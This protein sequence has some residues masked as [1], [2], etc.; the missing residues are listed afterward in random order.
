MKVKDVLRISTKNIK[1]HLKRNILIVAVMGI[2]F[3]LIFTINLWIQG[4]ENS[5]VEFANR[6]TGGKV[7][8][9]ATNSM[10]GMIIDDTI[11]QATKEEMM[12]DIE[13]H[14]GKVLGDAEQVGMFGSIVL[15]DSL[16]ENAIEGDISK[17]PKDAV[18][19]LVSTFLGEQLLEKSFPTEYTDATKKQRD[20]EEY[21]ASLIGKTF[22]DLYG[23]KYYVVGLTTGSF[24]I[25]NMSF[26]QLARGDS[27]LLNPILEFISMPDGMPIAVDNGKSET[28]YTGETLSLDEIMPSKSDKLV[29]VFDNNASAYDYFQHSKG[30]FMNVDFPNRTYFV[31]IVAGMSPEV[32]YIIN[33]IK[34]VVNVGSVILGLVAVIVVIFTSIRLIDQDKQNI[35]LYYSLGATTKQICIIY[36]CYFLWLMIGAIVFAFSLASIATLS[37]SFINQEMLGIQASLGFNLDI[38]PRVI[39]YGANSSVAITIGIMLLLAL[40]CVLVNKGRISKTFSEDVF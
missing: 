38:V 23:A 25:G 36:L 22:T 37:F 3:G 29:A 12:D 27:N 6:A 15:P 31:D 32:Q 33:G 35:A 21:R 39:W 20:Y 13:R 5:Y 8:I 24:H 2:I 17:A 30:K 14:Y 16:V 10:E 28:W 7:I 1:I 26:K 4:V 34:L 19:V 40:V 18:P 11:S 9:T